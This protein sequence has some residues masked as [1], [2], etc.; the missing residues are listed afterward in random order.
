VALPAH[1]GGMQFF[2]KV[3][4]KKATFFELYIIGIAENYIR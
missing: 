3:V 2:A 4:L 1:A